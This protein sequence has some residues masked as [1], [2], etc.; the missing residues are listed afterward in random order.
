[1]AEYYVSPSGN[2]ANVGS[3]ANP[4]QTLAFAASQLVAGDTLYLRAGTYLRLDDSHFA[5]VGT[6]GNPIR[7]QAYAAEVVT[8]GGL[9]LVGTARPYLEFRGIIFG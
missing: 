8:I 4:W 3:L 6:S 1:M 2:N 5:A 7:L 9:R